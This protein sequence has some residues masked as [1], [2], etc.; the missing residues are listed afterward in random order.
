MKSIAK[1]SSSCLANKILQND[2]NE[3]SSNIY[4]KRQSKKYDLMIERLL[5][6]INQMYWGSWYHQH[7]WNTCALGAEMYQCFMSLGKLRT[8]QNM[9]FTLYDMSLGIGSVTR[10][11]KWKHTGG[12]V[13]F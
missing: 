2:L 6:T 12:R 7:L 5:P 13:E 11:L 1:S 4:T 3:S 9:F 10:C 8:L